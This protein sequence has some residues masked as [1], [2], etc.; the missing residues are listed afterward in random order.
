MKAVGNSG[1]MILPLRFNFVEK[2]KLG[3]GNVEFYS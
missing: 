2:N 1:K 3:S